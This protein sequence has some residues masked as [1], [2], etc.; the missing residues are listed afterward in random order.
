MKAYVILEGEYSDRHVVGV[1]LDREMVTK[2]LNTHKWWDCEEYETDTFALMGE[3]NKLF[4]VCKEDGKYTVREEV[5]NIGC[6]LDAVGKLE[7]HKKNQWRNDRYYFTVIAKD[8]DHAI[9]ATQDR[10]AEYEAMRQ[11]V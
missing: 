7:F 6:Y 2:I 10:I 11:G 9:K 4:I 3:G 1:T 8:K 5:Y